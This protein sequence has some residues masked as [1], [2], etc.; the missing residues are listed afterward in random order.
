[1]LGSLLVTFAAS[2]IIL[3]ESNEELAADAAA[4]EN[5]LL[6]EKEDDKSA[7]TDPSDNSFNS[8]IVEGQPQKISNENKESLIRNTKER[9]TRNSFF[10]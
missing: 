5:N 2:M 3:T 8:S 4:A 9:R 1:M 10:N 6:K 7:N